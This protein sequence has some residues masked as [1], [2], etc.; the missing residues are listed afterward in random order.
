MF[1]VCLDVQLC[2]C[3]LGAH[4]CFTVFRAF[5][6]SFLAVA[7]GPSRFVHDGHTS[8]TTG[9]VRFVGWWAGEGHKLHTVVYDEWLDTG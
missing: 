4:L 5:S 8:A 3:W 6:V 7:M 9:S 1:G 2:T